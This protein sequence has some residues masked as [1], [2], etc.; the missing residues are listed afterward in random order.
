[1]T[2]K[3][4]SFRHITQLDVDIFEKNTI[5]TSQHLNTP[6]FIKHS[7]T[8]SKTLLIS[9]FLRLSVGPFPQLCAGQ[10]GCFLRR[11]FI[12][13]RW[14]PALAARSPVH[15]TSPVGKRTSKPSGPA[16]AAPRPQRHLAA[17][18]PTANDT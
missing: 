13:S 3:L 4:V 17:N 9:F 7:F 16:P 14:H 6:L 8:R 18:A 2:K 5:S 1:M 10:A 15:G 12:A 11:I